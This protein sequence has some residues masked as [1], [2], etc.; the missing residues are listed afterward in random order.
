MI[1]DDKE[2]GWGLWMPQN[3]N[4]AER[5]QKRAS[6]SW[7]QMLL[8]S[9][10]GSGL[11]T[12]EVRGARLMFR[13]MDDDGTG[14]ITRRKFKFAAERDNLDA[15][16]AKALFEIGDVHHQQALDFRNLCAVTLDIDA[17]SDVELIKQLG[18]VISR[19]RGP[20]MVPTAENNPG[21]KLETLAEIVRRR[22]VSDA[23]LFLEEVGQGMLPGE[24]LV[25]AVTLHRL[26]RS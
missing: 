8:L 3:P 21:I 16:T 18:S 24:T 11:N 19:L 9:I 20:F 7:T 22:T 5:L 12:K 25:T 10:I 23:E 2:S 6:C 14:L 26:L 15:N 4:F 17:F 1:Q 13:R